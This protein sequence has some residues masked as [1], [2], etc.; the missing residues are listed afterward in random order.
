MFGLRAQFLEKQ[1][2]NS[3]LWSYEHIRLEQGVKVVKDGKNSWRLVW[4]DKKA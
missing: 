2:K 4:D 3:K 1:Q